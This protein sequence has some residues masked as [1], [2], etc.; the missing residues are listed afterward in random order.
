MQNDLARTSVKGIFLFAFAAVQLAVAGG[1]PTTFYEFGLPADGGRPVSVI[2]SGGVLYGVT[3]LGGATG[4][5][6]AFSLT[7]PGSPST[8]WSEQLLWSFAGGADGAYPSA[9]LTPG[10]NGS[11]YGVTESGGPAG[12]GT[13]FSLNPP[14]SPGGA[15]T[16]TVLYS[17]AGQSDGYD[18]QGSLWVGPHGTLYGTTIYGGTAFGTVFS[19]T[20]PASPG[21]TW[22]HTILIGFDDSNAYGNPMG[23][24]AMGKD[25]RL[26]GTTTMGGTGGCPG[27]RFPGCG[28]LYS[29]KPP[30]SP[31]GSWTPTVLYNFPGPADDATP[32]GVVMGSREVL[33]GTVSYGPGSVAYSLT[34]PGSPGGPWAETVLYTF[35]D[36]TRG[37]D[38]T[39]SFAIRDNGTL[40]GATFIGGTQNGGTVYSLTPPAT[41]GGSWSQ[42]VLYNFSGATGRYASSVALG[43]GGVVYGV[44]GFGGI[45]QNGTVVS[46]APPGSGKATWSAT[47]L[48]LFT[49]GG[50]G[51]NPA[52]GIVNDVGLNQT[53]GEFNG[54]TATAVSDDG[55]AVVFHSFGSGTDGASPAGRLVQGSTEG[56]F[57]GVTQ[58]GG[59][60]GFG[61]A[62]SLILS[63]H[64]GGAA[65]EAVIYSFAGGADGGNPVAGLTFQN[66]VLYGTTPTGGDYG[67]GTVFSLTPPASGSTWTK[68]K[69]YSF[70]GGNDGGNPMGE[71]IDRNG[72]LYGTTYNGGTANAGVVFSLTPPAAPG[73][74]WTEAVVHPFQAGND[75]ANPKGKLLDWRGAFYGTTVNGGSANAGT[76]FL[77]EP[78]AGKGVWREAVLYTFQG[79]SD[80]AN[81]ESGLVVGKDASSGSENH[82]FYGSTRNGGAS[83]DGTL[84]LL[85]PSGIKKLTFTFGAGQ[86]GTHPTG[87]LSSSAIEHFDFLYGATASGGAYGGGTSYTVVVKFR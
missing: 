53:G 50:A 13:V 37:A 57:Y 28:V 45:S 32:N 19:L 15:W 24:L 52:G 14:T 63:T 6:T 77:L 38:P 75:G 26:Y 30:V 73:G 64:S 44:A 60:A 70:T 5:G 78:S 20:P 76:I 10:P 81:P 65:S 33:Y 49:A 48:H 43:T 29:L 22:T 79:G 7:P 56:T 23:S 12:L 31:G 39:G 51:A 61:T 9:P 2:E 69:L 67:Y 17:F 55:T 11:F 82:G 66:G 16:E 35:K 86:S 41:Q 72:I 42:Q 3:N 58:S 8:G 1:F 46:L 18:P 34:P 84:Y 87:E 68:T 71:L 36:K 59:T 47:V 74:A 83:G 54:G 4:Y 27:G 85:I 62:F 21:G 40:V 25:G 80:G